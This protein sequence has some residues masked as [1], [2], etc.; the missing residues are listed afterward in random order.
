MRSIDP[1]QTARLTRDLQ[2]VAK[3]ADHTQPLL[4]GVEQHG[5]LVGHPFR[6]AMQ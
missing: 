5:G 2:D 4:L 6:F 3:A 1:A